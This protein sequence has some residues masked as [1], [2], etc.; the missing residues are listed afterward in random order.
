MPGRRHARILAHPD[1][2]IRIGTEVRPVRA[3]VA[4]AAGYPDL[5]CEFVTMTPDYEFYRRRAG[6]RTIPLVVLEPR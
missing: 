5:W 4:T 1:T 2:T 6:G 3:R